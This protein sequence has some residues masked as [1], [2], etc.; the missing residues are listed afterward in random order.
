M[1]L[2]KSSARKQWS[3]CQ[4]SDGWAFPLRRRAECEGSKGYGAKRDAHM[5]TEDDARLRKQNRVRQRLRADRNEAL[6][7]ATRWPSHIVERGVAS[8]AAC[9][10]AP[11]QL[12]CFAIPSHSRE[13]IAYSRAEPCVKPRIPPLNEGQPRHSPFICSVSE[14]TDLER[15]VQS[16]D[17][18]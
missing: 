15:R 13:P 9:F 7:F 11:R 5:K 17:R 14:Q 1:Q 10:S 3:D 12:P 16:K 2:S 8:A 6:K 4:P 18:T